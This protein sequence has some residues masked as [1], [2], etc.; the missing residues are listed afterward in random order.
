MTG[1]DS[2]RGMALGLQR[3]AEWPKARGCARREGAVVA[4]TEIDELREQL[5]RLEAENATLRVVTAPTSASTAGG[6]AAARTR[7]LARIRLGAV[8]RDRHDP[9]ADLDRRRVGTRAARR[10]GRVRQHVRPARGRPRRAGPHHRQDVT[11]VIR[12]GRR[13]V[14]HRSGLRR[15][16]RRSICRR[17]RSPPSSC[18]A[19]PPRTGSRASSTAR[20]RKR[21]RVGCVL[22]RLGEGA[23]RQP[24]VAG[25]DRHDTTARVS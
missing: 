10:R 11:A 12:V 24:Q 8:H 3:P 18:C 23:A 4:E 22:G 2:P 7:P 19:S 6:E 9:G 14:A 25:R 17:V 5:A 21:R 15:L 1:D 13:S 16:R 20:S